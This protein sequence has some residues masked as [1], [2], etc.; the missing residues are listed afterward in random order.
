MK[1][2]FL[3]SCFVLI[4]TTVGFSQEKEFPKL[5]GQYLG[6][7]P[8]GMK[9]KLFA[10]GI[11]SLKGRYELNSVFSPDGKEFYFALSVTSKEEKAKGFYRY[12]LMFTKIVDGVWTKP[13]RL[14]LTGD[15]SV[16][17]IA[18]SPDGNRLY[19]CSEMPTFWESA[20]G[21]DIWYVERTE[22]GWSKPINAG[23]NINS[24][25][26][27]TQPSFTTDGTMYF[28][29]YNVVSKLNNVDIYS[30]KFVDGEFQKPV[31]LGDGVNSK[32]NEGNSFVAP[33]GSYIHFAR[34]GMP[35]S[36]NGGKGAYISFRKKDGTWGKAIYIE[37]NTNLYGSLA[38]LTP[39]GK[40]FFYSSR[41]RGK[42]DIYWVDVKAIEKLKP[43]E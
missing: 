43:K 9:A 17:D 6:Q 27:E 5:T 20:E 39:D 1:K 14:K 31:P 8:P 18:L 15:Y 11:I 37:P 24:P 38:A 29:S 34:W 4:F 21:F 42:G 25:Q 33:D 12:D 10:P 40:Y 16:A 19:F 23:K 22:N 26:G 30:S 13:K 41:R 3:I 36:I 7:T 28:P 2:I 32:Y 35:E